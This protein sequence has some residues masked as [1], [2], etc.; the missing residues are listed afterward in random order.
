MRKG[1]TGCIINRLSQ[2]TEMY[3]RKLYIHIYVFSCLPAMPK[4]NEAGGGGVVTEQNFI[5][6]NSP[7]P[8]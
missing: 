5:R 7:Y 8:F 4:E 6:G 2:N 3:L 1:T